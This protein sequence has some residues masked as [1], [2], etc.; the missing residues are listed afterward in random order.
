MDQV[1]PVSAADNEIEMKNK[2]FRSLE[3]SD[4]TGRLSELCFCGPSY[5]TFPTGRGHDESYLA[6]TL[7]RENCKHEH[8]QAASK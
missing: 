5:L 8:A 2:L 4:T 3:E 6:N 7:F 1:I